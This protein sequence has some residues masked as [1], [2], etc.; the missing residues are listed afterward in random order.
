MFIIDANSLML[1]KRHYSTN[2]FVSL[3]SNICQFID[4]GK[5]ISLKE[6]QNELTKEDKEFWTKIHNKNDNFFIDPQDKE[7]DC[8]S[9][10]EG[11]KVY[12][13]EWSEGESMSDPLLICFGLAN[14]YIVLT[15]ENQ[16]SEMR[17]PYVCRELGV[18]CLNLSQFF[19]YNEWK[20]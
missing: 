4:N 9:Q 17:I 15:E 10:L 6:V 2:V 1:L 3:W 11:F 13:E 12:D 18:E 7:T 19:E 20:F 5:L 8:L 14:N 16:R